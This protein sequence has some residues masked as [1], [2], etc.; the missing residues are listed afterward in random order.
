MH[1]TLI[2]VKAHC[3]SFS[4]M[5]MPGDYTVPFEFTLPHGIPSSIMFMNKHHRDKPKA[6][7]K[8]RV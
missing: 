4:S 2:D 8:Y 1:R 6:V 3:F 5:L 7:I